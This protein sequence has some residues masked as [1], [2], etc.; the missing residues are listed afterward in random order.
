[1]FT[2]EQLRTLVSVTQRGS[3]AGV[4]TAWTMMGVGYVLFFLLFL[5]SRH[6]PRALAGAG[7]VTSALLAPVAVVAFVFPERTDELKPLLL[8][9]LLTEIVTGLWLLTKGL[10]PTAAVDA[11]A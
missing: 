2:T 11:K 7:I 6:L 9:A 1:V 3:H 4:T 10:H 5:R 8:P